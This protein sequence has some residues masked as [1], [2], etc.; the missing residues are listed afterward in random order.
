MHQLKDK[1]VESYAGSH[2]QTSGVP[3]LKIHHAPQRLQMDQDVRENYGR[4]HLSQVPEEREEMDQ[5]WQHMRHV[6]HKLPTELGVMTV[7]VPSSLTKASL[8]V[9]LC[10]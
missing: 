10:P 2:G 8:H 6:A 4:W 5:A 1:V 3:L 9:R 7:C